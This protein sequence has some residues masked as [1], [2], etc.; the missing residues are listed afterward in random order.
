MIHDKEKNNYI[1]SGLYMLYFYVTLVH[2]VFR[3]V[4]WREPRFILPLKSIKSRNNSGEV[5]QL[6]DTGYVDCNCF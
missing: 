1:N 5:Q 4:L 3:S 6:N 2:S